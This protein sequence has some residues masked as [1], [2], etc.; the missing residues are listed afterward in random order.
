[1]QVIIEYDS[2]KLSYS[3]QY[4]VY[5]VK[6]EEKVINDFKEK[7]NCLSF[8]NEFIDL[9][10]KMNIKYLHFCGDSEYWLMK[11]EVQK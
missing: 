6:N 3:E 7:M 2:T 11:V 4:K 9:P 8:I 10:L 5:D 1:M